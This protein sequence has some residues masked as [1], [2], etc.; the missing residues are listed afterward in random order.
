MSLQWQLARQVPDDTAQLGQTLLAPENVY[1]QIGDRLDELFP[2]RAAM[3]I[4]MK[5]LG[6]AQFRLCGW[7]W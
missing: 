3:L 5:P 2:T 1:R 4:C 6:E 7:R